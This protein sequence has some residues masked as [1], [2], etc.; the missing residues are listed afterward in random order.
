M[1]SRRP[2]ARTPP[3]APPPSPQGPPPTRSE[4]IC[5]LD[6][7]ARN[8]ARTVLEVREGRVRVLD[9]SKLDWSA[10]WE[11]RVARDVLSVRADV[12]LVEKQC[13]RSPHA[14]VL[15]FLRGLLHGSGTRVLAR[16]PPLRGGTYRERKRRSVALFAARLRLFGL[17]ADAPPAAKLDDVADSFH[18]AL[19][20][21][22]RENGK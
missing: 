20:Y 11:R 7:G 1:C 9:V 19:A 3:R 21:A 6:L 16:N 17:H 14:K 18:L 5:A 22:L 12:V 13:P 15:Y 2:S 4:R 8:P 10:D